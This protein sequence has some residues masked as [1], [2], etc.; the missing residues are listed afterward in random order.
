[1][2]PYTRFVL[3]DSGLFPDG[4]YNMSEEIRPYQF[5][6]RVIHTVE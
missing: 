5:V 2:H 3:E 1:M 4:K 6:N